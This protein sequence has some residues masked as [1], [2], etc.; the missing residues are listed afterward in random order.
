[1][2]WRSLRKCIFNSAALSCLVLL[3]STSYSQ[4]DSTVTLDGLNQPVEILKDKWG[5]SHI[6]AQTEHDL[7]FAQGYSAARDR[8]FQ[9]EIWRAQATGTTAEMLGPRMLDRDQGA[10]LFKFR[11]DMITEMQ[12]YHP[13]GVEIISAFVDGVNA[14]IDEALQNPQSLPLP[15]KLLGIQPQH[16][17]PEVVISRHQGLRSNIRTELRTGRAVC[18]VGE[19]KVRE[20]QYYRPHQPI[21]KLDELIDCDALVES[22]ILR[23][24][25]AHTRPIR[26]EPEDVALAENRNSATAFR[27]LASVLTAEE[28]LLQKRDKENIG[29]N[30]WVVSGDLTQ[31]GW[32]MMINDPHRS[33]SVPS[34][35][36]WAHLVGPG[37]NVIGGGEPEIPGISIGHNEQG[38][39]GLTV[40]NTDSEDLYVYQTN[41][42]NSN[43]YR[44]RDRWE[45]MQ[46]IEEVIDVKGSSPVT[47]ALKYTGHGPVTYE[48]EARNLAYAIRPAWLEVG[49][50]PYLASLRM[51]QAS[52][53]EEFREATNYSNM[54]GENM[55]WAD[56]DGNIGW[57]AV[58]IAP[59]RR[60]FS[61]M[62]PVPGDGRYE[63]DGYLE[64][65]SKPND[66]N[67][68]RGFI[69]TSNS[70]Y[71]PPDFPYMDAIG[72]TWTDPYR[73]ARSSEVLASGRKFNMMDMVELQ[74]DYLSIPARSLVP[75]FKEL[76]AS[77]PQV[78][79]ARQALLDWDFVLD[80]DSIE[81]GIYIAFERQLLDNIETLKVPEVAVDYLTVGMKTTIDMLL[82]PNGDFGDDPLQGRDQ[83][84]LDT[85]A[86]GIANLREKLGPNMQNWVYGQADYKHALI[87]HP[88]ASAVNDEIRSR[89]NV[90]P[91]PRGGN[92]YTVGAASSGDNQTSGASF[93]IFV[94]TRDWDNTL[95]MN[96]PGQVGDPDSPLYDNLFE[97][98]ANDKV[99]PAF[100]SREKIETVLYE[101][102][103]LIPAR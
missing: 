6:Y 79:A 101:T 82:A 92:S 56:R 62:V 87:R 89:L 43:Q 100:F 103:N 40:F 35:R 78:E 24:Y 95:G 27:Q 23:L 41:P 63:W 71:T 14:Y 7:F 8:L 9:F 96:T 31:D 12:H 3:G 39:W 1:M 77:D 51:D 47:V 15:F 54:P 102:L 88:L 68:D 34:L 83:F 57:Q 32:P 65:K 45:E 73:W 99:F 48:D 91:V 52:S 36:Y 49:G 50:A 5:I 21:L 94:D 81:A 59:L 55:I 16:W 67:P 44:F 75:F 74:H 84:L 66:L 97:L 10:R 86:Q 64:I 30:N 72:Y 93:R 4:L 69:E 70:N 19:A 13:N 25:N 28:Q 33:Q 80:K 42:A 2:N 18:T 90:G 38:A 22:D 20:L 60:N 46:I 76:T 85:L 98:W 37:W 58:G 11:G 53:W 29:S 61:G 26:F 17:T